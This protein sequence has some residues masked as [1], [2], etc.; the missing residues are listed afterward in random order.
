MADATA[1][2]E[3]LVEA[4]DMASGTITQAEAQIESSVAG[5]EG[6]LGTFSTSID[7]T[8]DV[9][10]ELEVEGGRIFLSTGDRLK[11]LIPSFSGM[12]DV[13]S[14]TVQATRALGSTVVEELGA[15]TTGAFDSLKASASSAAESLS[16]GFTNAAD[17]VTEFLTKPRSMLDIFDGIVSA[18]PKVTA[19][20]AGMATQANDFAQNLLAA[21]DAQ[22]GLGGKAGAVFGPLGKGLGLVMRLLNPFIS[23]IVDTLSPAFE[24]LGAMLKNTLAPLGFLFETM[25]QQL[26][27]LIQKLITPLVGLLST[28]AIHLGNVLQNV[29]QVGA[30]G[31][32][33]A[34]AFQSLLPVLME[35]TGVVVRLFTKLFPVALK[36]VQTV[37]PI[38]TKLIG[39]LAKALVPVIDKIGDMIV[40]VAPQFYK[41]FTDTLD[42][43]MPLI[44]P[45]LKLSTLLLTKVFGPLLVQGIKLVL[46]GLQLLV[47]YIRDFA[48]WLGPWVDLIGDQVDEFFSNF[49]KY[50]T[51][52]YI[53]FMKPIIDPIKRLIKFIFEGESPSL[54]DAITM[55]VRLVERGMRTAQMMIRGVV[56]FVSGIPMNVMGWVDT[57]VDYISVGWD[58]LTAKLSAG[59]TWLRTLI[60]TAITGYLTIVKDAW[61]GLL[62]FL[63]LG[64]FSANVEGFFNQMIRAVQS[65]VDAMKELLNYWVI[66]F[67]NDILSWDPPV[68]PGGSISNIIWG[69]DYRIPE[70]AEGGIATGSEGVVAEVGEAGNAELIQPL[71]PESVKANL[72]PLVADLELPGLDVATDWL[73]RIY[74]VLT[75]TLN[76]KQVGGPQASAEMV[77]ERDDLGAGLGLSGMGG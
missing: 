1:H 47:P 67:A 48:R 10:D 39:M 70:L 19:R 73:E 40:E 66:D 22:G 27:P 54:I 65:P 35:I 41:L 61:T 55:P 5:I 3:M 7:D 33:I 46:G 63:G 15:Q 59:F 58:W 14:D 36:I 21:Q 30:A 53:L 74:G 75:G 12:V 11:A 28:M 68:I 57:M 62:K 49:E 16:T 6:T 31:N 69:E 2:M 8:I 51:D 13:F 37:L 56:D 24:T 29:L 71:T 26:A 38:V 76:V 25:A 44:Q 50:A 42:A 9:L 43:L 23:A 17:S 32:P 77:R 52:F 45:L 34:K 20:L 18:A 4:R 60:T 72:G 64:E